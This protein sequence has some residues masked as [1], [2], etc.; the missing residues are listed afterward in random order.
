MRIRDFCLDTLPFRYR[1]GLYDFAHKVTCANVIAGI[2]ITVINFGC[3]K[4]AQAVIA[5]GF[6]R[7]MPA[8]YSAG[9]IERKA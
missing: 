6:Y 2:E 1:K 5:V 8:Q 4:F 7:L 9:T 3:L